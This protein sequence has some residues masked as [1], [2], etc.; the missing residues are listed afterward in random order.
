M[1]SLHFV[2]FCVFFGPSGCQIN[3][4]PEAVDE[5]KFT[6]NVTEHI[7]VESIDCV[8]IPHR[9]TFP[10]GRVAA[11]Y[12]KML[13]QGDPSNVIDKKV[14]YDADSNKEDS[15]SIKNLPCGEYDYGFKL[16][17]GCNQTYTFPER[18]HVSVL[19]L[20][21]KPTVLVPL[22]TEEE[23]S[24]LIC[25][26]A[27]P[28]S[29]R[30]RVCWKWTKADGQS[31]VLSDYRYGILDQW[32][33]GYKDTLRINPT[34]HHHNTNITCVAEYDN[35]L[36]EATVT[37]NVKFKP[38]I[39]NDSH[40]LVKGELLV[41]MCVS[42]G[43]PLPPISWP[44]ENLTTFSVTSLRIAQTVRSTFTMPASEYHSATVKCTSS[45]E[46]GLAETS[47]IIRNSEESAK[48]NTLPGRRKGIDSAL[49]WIAGLCFSLNL[50][51][52]TALIVHI[53][54]RRNNK[55]K[56]QSKEID[57]Y[58]SLKKGG[59]EEEYSVISAKPKPKPFTKTG[60]WL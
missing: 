7:R 15:F 24:E 36:T 38:K 58:M 34:A 20:A 48:P 51:F 9:V 29:Q 35:D 46:R 53:C 16:E 17:W 59:V 39:T 56:E 21:T 28:C 27:K 49:P 25:G 10:R 12:Q 44:L 5:T 60:K 42:W 31:A 4:I 41:C 54:Q 19:P 6:V 55:Q 37:L 52:I 26:V 14:V 22:L 32:F 43:N 47:I 3:C 11:R 45:N 50:V 1:T 57:I 2:I 23:R 13:F 33:Y 40:C 8:V 30:L 18:V